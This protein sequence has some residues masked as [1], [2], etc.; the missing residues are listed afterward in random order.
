MISSHV[1]LLASPSR[2]QSHLLLLLLLLLLL[3]SNTASAFAQDSPSDR[4]DTLSQAQELFARANEHYASG[5]FEPALELYTRLAR[6]GF[7]TREVWGNA[8]NAAYRLGDVG[9][10]VLYYKR[11]LRV[12]PDYAQA[13]ENLEAIQPA[14]NILHDDS[15]GGLLIE[16]FRGTR[17]WPWL[18]VAEAVFIWL[19]VSLFLL[20]RTSRGTEA[21]SLWW[22][23]TVGAAV[24]FLLAAGL[25]ATHGHLRQTAGDAV[26]IEDKVVTRQGP[27]E[28]FFSQLELPAG[29]V[30]IIRGQPE[31]GWVRFRLL[32][33]RSG[34]IPTGSLQR[35]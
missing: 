35:I 29:T 22:S 5:E 1:C 25:L 17:P 31:R 18:A 4:I 26:V 9:H 21:R 8:G 20:G 27:G 6:A 23:R 24:L 28:E 16:A 32:D 12:D 13:R 19:A 14:T 3:Y 34:Y 2:R 7:G 33:G 11:A 15:F 10:A 30:G